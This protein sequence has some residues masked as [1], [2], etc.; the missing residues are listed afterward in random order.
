MKDKIIYT[1]EMV[2]PNNIVKFEKQ[3]DKVSGRFVGIVHI[4]KKTYILLNQ[5]RPLLIK[6]NKQL[7]DCR[8]IFKRDDLVYIEL[9]SLKK[10]Y[11]NNKFLITV[12]KGEIR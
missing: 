4:R 3:Y 9:V 11:C 7:Q 6:C 1:N 2:S 12:Y 8:D 10:R 5:K